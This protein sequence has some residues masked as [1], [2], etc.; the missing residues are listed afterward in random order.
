MIA[1]LYFR[2]RLILV[3]SI[4]IGC[5]P[6]LETLP[7]NNETNSDLILQIPDGFDFKTHEKVHININDL[8]GDAL[9]QVFTE[10]RKYNPQIPDSLQINY[11]EVVKDDVFVLK[12]P[13]GGGYG[14]YN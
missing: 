5:V 10:S 6:D 1:I 11:D 2:V 4:F 7:D 3:F 13:G 12:T 14:Q 8:K 9:Y